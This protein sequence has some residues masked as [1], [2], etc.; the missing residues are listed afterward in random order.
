[1]MRPGGDCTKGALANFFVLRRFS[2]RVGEICNPKDDLS[3]HV[4]D[5]HIP[6]RQ[7]R[8]HA[9]KAPGIL[10]LVQSLDRD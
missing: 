6:V 2:G 3:G 5:V 8:H 7:L 4:T 9:A 1:M 10:D